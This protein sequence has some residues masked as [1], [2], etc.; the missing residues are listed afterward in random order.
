MLKTARIFFLL[1]AYC[2]LATPLRAQQAQTNDLLTTA[3]QQ[4]FTPTN[5]KY[6]QGVGIGY[7]PTAGSGLV[8]NLAAGTAVCNN[9][10]Y[11]YA[12]GTLT[13]TAS[14]TNYVYLDASAS[15]APGFN[16][17]GWTATTRPIATV[18][19]R[20]S[21]ITSITDVRTM[22][23]YNT[24]TGS[25]GPVIQVNGSNTSNQ[26]TLDFVNGTYLTVSSPGSGQIKY[27]ITSLPNIGIAGGGTGQTTANAA[28]NALSPMTTEGD[29]EFFHSSAGTRL[30]IGSSGQCLNSNGTD[31]VWGACTG[32][33]ITFQA[34]GA[35][36]ASQSP[37]NF[38][39]STYL[40][41]TNPSA[42]Q[43]QISLTSLPTQPISAGGTGQVTAAAA[44]SAL[45]PLSSEGDLVFQHTGAGT[46]LAVGASNQVLCSNGT[47]P[48]WC[49]LGVGGFGNQY[50]NMVFAGPAS[51]VAASP[52]FRGLTPGDLPSSITSNTS[53]TA[54]GLATTPTQCSGAAFAQGIAANGNANCIGNQ[55]AN[56]IYAAPYSS[57]GAPSFRTLGPADIPAGTLSASQFQSFAQ[58]GFLAG[59]Y[60][61][62]SGTP[63]VRTIGMA[64]LP[65]L[66]GV[67]GSIG[68]SALSVNTCASGTV[69]ITGAS[70]A[71][72]AG[73]A[74][75][76]TPRTYP[77]AGFTWSQPYLSATDTVT[78][79]VCAA[80]AGTPTASVYN[81]RV[82]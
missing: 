35:N 49:A 71:V 62:G 37:I 45:S 5:V 61:G 47:D 31:P 1:T 68:G 58:N 7:W 52:T 29:L 77:G 23:Y 64:D 25:G 60:S 38:I 32:S 19:T 8:L 53:G 11:T 28:F 42:G 80:V 81:V 74:I 39:N 2:L 63:S 82:F 13:L 44:F 18:V 16:T 6:V 43:Y 54:A 70:N 22:F 21:V 36:L 78:V 3:I 46:R 56:Y 40:T 57:A 73:A 48:Y 17:T 51:G 9:T 76:A 15:C 26:S 14:A 20:D 55:N 33:G 41:V 75:T 34:N 50:A 30:G 10:V 27:D 4:A 65:V 24:V 67:T 72:S 79:S 69:S 12:G 66:S 59:P